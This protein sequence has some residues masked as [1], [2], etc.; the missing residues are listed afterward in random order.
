MKTTPKKKSEEQGEFIRVKIPMT[1]ELY[2]KVKRAS[3]EAGLSMDAWINEE[4]RRYV[5]RVRARLNRG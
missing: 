4:A 1:R 2:A 5:L 3:E